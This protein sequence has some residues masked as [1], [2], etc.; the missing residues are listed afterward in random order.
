[1]KQYIYKITVLTTNKSYIGITNNPG[2]R[3]GQHMHSARIN[4][5]GRKN[6]YKDWIIKGIDNYKFEILEEFEFISKRNSYNKEA[7]YIKL[8]DTFNNGYNVC[9]YSSKHFQGSPMKGRKL[10]E[11]T[12]KKISENHCD[13]R[14]IKNPFAKEYIIEDNLGNIYKFQTRDKICEELNISWKQMRIL[15]SYKINEWYIPRNHNKDKRSFK[16]LNKNFIN[17]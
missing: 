9:E 6:F 11:E 13:E 12:R 7:Y 14:G 1:M 16:L 15:L 8:Y 5:E 2:R 3:L 10:S 4:C 17:K